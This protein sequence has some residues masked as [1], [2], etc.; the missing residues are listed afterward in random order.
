MK[1][2][3]KLESSRFEIPAI[4]WESLLKDPF[5]TQNKSGMFFFT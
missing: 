1:E 2:R 3:R 5:T 4:V